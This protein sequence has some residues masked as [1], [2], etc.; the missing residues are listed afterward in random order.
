[1]HACMHAIVTLLVVEVFGGW[2][3]EAI[4]VLSTYGK[5]STQLCRPQNEVI[6]VNGTISAYIS[7]HA[8]LF[9]GIVTERDGIFRGVPFRSVF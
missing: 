9:R 2:R 5:V 3:I 6:K 4:N 7:T 8:H 1:M